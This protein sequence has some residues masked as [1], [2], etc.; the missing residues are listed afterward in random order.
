MPATRAEVWR[1]WT[2]SEGV[3]TF[4][5]QAANI[6]LEPGGAFELYFDTEAPPGLQGSEGMRVLSY[7]PGE[8][9][10]FEWNAP[11]RFPELRNGPRTWVVVRLDDVGARATRV[12]LAHLGW[13]GGGEWD[14]VHSYFDRAWDTVLRR[15]VCR[16]ESGP[17][18]WEIPDP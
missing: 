6:R 3:V 4:F 5:A 14:Q 1:A 13:R 15:L 18:D 9:L 8:M 7:L 12:R 16:F 10:S 2:T 11:P 17:V